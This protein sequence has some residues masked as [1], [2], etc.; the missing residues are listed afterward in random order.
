MARWNFSCIAVDDDDGEEPEQLMEVAVDLVDGTA[1]TGLNFAVRFKQTTPIRVVSVDGVPSVVTTPRPADGREADDQLAAPQL[2]ELQRLKAELEQMT[3]QKMALEKAMLDKQ[4][5]VGPEVAVCHVK[6]STKM[7]KCHSPRCLVPTMYHKLKNTA[8]IGSRH[9][10]STED[11]DES[12]IRIAFPDEDK[13]RP[14]AAIGDESRAQPQHAQYNS[15]QQ[16]SHRDALV[17]DPL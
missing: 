10:C 8:G 13:E 2:S 1:V 11:A 3:Q 6:A 15:Q 16:S 5:S 7:R 9:S 12:S 17:R 4:Y 14:L